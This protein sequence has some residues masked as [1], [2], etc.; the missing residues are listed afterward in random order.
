MD[1]VKSE[2]WKQALTPHGAASSNSTSFLRR[3]SSW[4]RPGEPRYY[5]GPVVQ[6]NRPPDGA[7][8]QS[9]IEGGTADKWL[10]TL[11]RLQSRP[12][13]RQIPQFVDKTLSM[14]ALPN[15]MTKLC[16]PSFQ[17]RQQTSS[18]SPS[19]YESSVGSLESMETN[20]ASYGRNTVHIKPSPST[21]RA[22][23]CSLAPVRFGWL[24]IKRHVILTDISNSDCHHDNSRCQKLKSPITP[25]LLSTPAKLKGSRTNEPESVCCRDQK[26][27]VKTSY[28]RLQASVNLEGCRNRSQTWNS[29][30]SMTSIVDRG[31]SLPEPYRPASKDPTYR[32]A[33]V[34]EVPLGMPTAGESSSARRYS[35]SIS[36]ITIISRKVTRS[37]SLPDTSCPNPPKAL[38]TPQRKVLVV[39]VT[40][41][42]MKMKTTPVA[43]AT[44]HAIVLNSNPVQDHKGYDHPVVMRRKA[45]VVNMSE[46]TEGLHKTKTAQYRHSYTEGFNATDPIKY[47]RNSGVS[48]IDTTNTNPS[49]GFTLSVQPGK[50]QWR[51]SALQHRSS[52]SLYF[53]PKDSNTV[54]KTV[55]SPPR[56]LSCDAKVFNQT[57]LGTNALTEPAFRNK[58]SPVPQKTNI[59]LVS[60]SKE[61]ER[62]KSAYSSEV[63]ISKKAD[64]ERDGA[65]REEP[66]S[67]IK[68]LTL[69][70]VADHSPLSTDVLALNAAAVIANI[71]LQTRQRPNLNKPAE[72]QSTSHTLAADDGRNDDSGEPGDE[73]GLN[74][75]FS[76][77]FGSED[78]PPD[79]ALAPLSLRE[80]LA[81][82][83][84]DF[85]QRS[86][87]RVQALEMRSQE[88]QKDALQKT[89]SSPQRPKTIQQQKDNPLKSKD[90]S[91]ISGKEARMRPRRNYDLL[92]EVRK[93]RE[94]QKRIKEEEKRKL[95]SRT[96]RLRAELFKKKLLDQVLQRGNN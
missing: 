62:R 96:N 15:E 73:D 40:E 26:T 52:I 19:L 37:S 60:F 17:R 48:L 54:D 55:K 11:E 41:E 33:S 39:K 76:G 53:S 78:F 58:S 59:D 44:D 30:N 69:L 67:E 38:L 24:P 12:L 34:P 88:R 70:K 14:P 9:C 50:N 87:A 66:N 10:Q 32:R 83:R 42:K 56:P 6:V 79:P 27:P 93:R 95:A 81:V 3:S 28:S 92:P 1:D 13:Q 63:V 80:A 94:E 4:R 68:P 90:K 16:P 21:E 64:F 2:R 23:F 65:L 31:R 86:Q 36:S 46:Q 47:D 7:R 84:P 45:S 91:K 25:V 35:S 77:P 57:E 51:S 29:T 8:P 43:S 71:K 82:R 18:V 75:R 20:G 61:E 85:I 22:E 89:L 74:E 72:T 5:E 49:Q